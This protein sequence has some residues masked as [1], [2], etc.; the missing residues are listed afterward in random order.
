MDEEFELRLAGRFEASRPRL[1]AMAYRMLG[2]LSDADDAVQEG[3]LHAARATTRGGADDVANLEGW[4]TTIVARVCLDMLRSRKSRRE[5]PLDPDVVLHS[6]AV[7][8]PSG[9]P[10]TVRGAAAV[11]GGARAASERARYGSIALVNGAPGLIMAP[12]GRLLIAL[13][14][15]FSG[16]K[17]SQIDVI[18]DPDRLAALDLALLD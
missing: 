1:R 4:F 15:T 6:D 18:G 2:S 10:L 12:R 16:D 17:I 3:W 7:A 9:I 13:A 5:E 11:A 14:F 8:S